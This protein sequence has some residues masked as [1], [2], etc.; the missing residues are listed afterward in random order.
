MNFY[1][2]TVGVPFVVSF[3]TI[4]YTS[5]NNEKYAKYMLGLI[6][7]IVIIIS[8]LFLSDN[9]NAAGGLFLIIGLF[10]F[11]FPL[12]SV[13]TFYSWYFTIKNLTS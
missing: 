11:V 9:D 5:W 13:A 7:L 8:F 1:S 6:I 4:L 2:T 3:G 12:L 10:V